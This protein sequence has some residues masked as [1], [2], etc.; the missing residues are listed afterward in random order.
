MMQDELVLVLDDTHL[1][2][3]F[4]RDAGFANVS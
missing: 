1:D 3:Q 2:V 4:H